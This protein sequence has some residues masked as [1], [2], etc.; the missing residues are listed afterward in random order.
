M[1]SYFFSMHLDGWLDS[2]TAHSWAYWFLHL[3]PT[4]L[5]SQ[6]VVRCQVL[7]SDLREGKVPQFELDLKP[8]APPKFLLELYIKELSDIGLDIIK[9]FSLF[10]CSCCI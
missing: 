9:T 7:N 4:F 8:H 2:G 3:V 1:H 6:K 5:N 10:D